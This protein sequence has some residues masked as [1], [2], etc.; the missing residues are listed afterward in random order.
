MVSRLDVAL[1]AVLNIKVS[2]PMPPVRMS[3]PN[4][5][6]SESLPIPP[7]NAFVALSTLHRPT[8]DAVLLD[9]EFKKVITNSGTVSSESKEFIFITMLWRQG[10]FEDIIFLVMK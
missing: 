2:L 9:P 1:S 5:P 6:K 10:F 4:P 3:L 7:Y 8:F